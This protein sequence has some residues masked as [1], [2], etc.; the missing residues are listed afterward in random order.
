[1]PQ[2]GKIYERVGDVARVDD[3]ARVTAFDYADIRSGYVASNIKATGKKRTSRGVEGGG[4]DVI[5]GIIAA[6]V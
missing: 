1:M 6:S 3:V 2:S 4:R 5:S